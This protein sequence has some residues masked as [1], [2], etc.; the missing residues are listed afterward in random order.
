M[1]RGVIFD[2]NGTLSDDIR[3]VVAVANKTAKKLGGNALSLREFRRRAA[4]PYYPFYRDVM[5]CKVPKSELEKWYRH[6]FKREKTHAGLFPDSISLLRFLK[7]RN[8]KV[9]IVSSHP[10]DMLASETKAYGLDCL[11]SFVRGGCHTKQEHIK[12]FLKQFELEPSEVIF[13]GDMVFDIVEGKKCGVITAAYLK[14]VD[15]KSKLLA[16]RPDLLLPTL[17]SLKE[18]LKKKK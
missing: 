14:G 16:S 5:G 7:R 1:I 8:I 17:A 9:G 18:H 6:Y 2:W 15:T 11:L 3:K 12:D 10:A 4:N 13:V